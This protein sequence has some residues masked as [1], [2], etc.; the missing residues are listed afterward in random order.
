MSDAAVVT[1]NEFDQ[2]PYSYMTPPCSRM[3][4]MHDKL[5]EGGATNVRPTAARPLAEG[6]EGRRKGV[7]STFAG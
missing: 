2:S 5:A 7:S 4:Q 1:C 6:T 3:H